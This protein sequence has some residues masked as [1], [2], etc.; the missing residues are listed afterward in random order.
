MLNRLRSPLKKNKKRNLITYTNPESII[1]EEFR[2]IRTNIQFTSEEQNCKAILM[3][4][5]S[6]EEGKSTTVANLAVSLAQQ[7]DKVLIIDANLRSP[8]I[9]SIF[10]LNNSIGLSSVLTNRKKF[11]EAIKETNIGKLEVLSSGPI[12]E[13][14][15]ELLGSNSF[16]NLLDL[17]SQMFDFILIDSPA[18]LEY[19][20]TKILANQCKNVILVVRHGKS[21]IEKA[22]EAKKVLKIAKA[23]LVGAIINEKS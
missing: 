8:R 13:N 16:S 9:H 15:A 19:S 2:A 12:P 6:T 20:D 4:S 18:V 22:I 5:P 3:T 23:E 10:K 17:A 11:E 7:K 21:N 1:T 14:P